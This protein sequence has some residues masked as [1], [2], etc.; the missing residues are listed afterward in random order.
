M[1]EKK[2]CLC[3]GEFLQNMRGGTGMK[4][5]EHKTGLRRLNIVE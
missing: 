3:L 4:F 1:G 5:P 2:G